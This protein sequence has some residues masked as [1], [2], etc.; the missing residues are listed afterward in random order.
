M[1]FDIR[2]IR[3]YYDS[4][5]RDYDY[6]EL[7]KIGVSYENADFMVS[8]GVPEVY[9]D[10]V[11]YGMDTIQKTIIEDTEFIIIGHY[12]CHGI[13]SPKGLFLK[14]GSD[15][16]FTISSVHYPSIYMLNK[17]LRTFFLFDLI[18]SELAMKMRREGEY[19][20][21]KYA[22]ELRKFFEQHDPEAMNYVEGYWSHFIED[23][24]T[25]L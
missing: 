12:A 17:N 8:I 16:L 9:D 14:E 4:N 10:F 25:G 3:D 6:D 21:Q 13:L 20:S 18:R 15:K 23:Y 7:V 19:S 5:L 2:E 1:D 11:F 22:Q 24:E